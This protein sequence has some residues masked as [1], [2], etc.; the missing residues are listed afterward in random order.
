MFF[1]LCSIYDIIKKS[2]EV[3]K[4]DVP[5]FNF[6][7][8]NIP[9]EDFLEAKRMIGDKMNTVIREHNPVRYT[10]IIQDYKEYI[11]SKF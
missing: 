8:L 9:Q 4:E 1:Y 2:K 10:G 5:A 7:A 6:I 3:L 11:N